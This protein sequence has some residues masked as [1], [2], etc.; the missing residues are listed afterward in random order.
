MKKQTF[1]NK[2]PLNIFINWLR[3]PIILWASFDLLTSAPL[4]EGTE[5]E[6]ST[7]KK[8]VLRSEAEKATTGLSVL[9]SEQIKNA[10]GTFGDSLNALTTLP[11]IM[12]TDSLFGPLVI[13]GAGEG[14]NR[15]F[16][17]GIPTAKPQHFGGLHSVMNNDFIRT[18]QLHSVPE[19][20]PS[21]E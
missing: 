11:G 15:Y 16:V 21:T 8:I 18:R 9:T 12:R 6:L 5:T 3:L 7:K 2:F 13:R 19:E 14:A 20:K 17:D 4:P 1:A 10:P